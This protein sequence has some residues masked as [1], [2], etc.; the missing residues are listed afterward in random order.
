MKIL[1]L[2]STTLVFS[3]NTLLFADPKVPSDVSWSALTLDTTGN[4]KKLLPTYPIPYSAKWATNDYDRSFS[5]SAVDVD[6]VSFNYA[7]NTFAEEGE[8]AYAWD[9]SNVPLS[10]LPR[11]ATYR[12]AYTIGKNAVVFDGKRSAVSVKL[13]PEPGLTFLL[14]VSGLTLLRRKKI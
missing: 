8:G 9:Y 13:L 2:L 11:D 7:V 14:A 12:L 1:L 5:L 4:T 10:E 6:D 3:A